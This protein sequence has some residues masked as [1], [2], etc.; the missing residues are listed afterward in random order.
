MGQVEIAILLER[1]YPEYLSAKDIVS[2]LKMS[3]KSVLSCLRSLKKREEVEYK[4]S[5]GKLLKAGWV[6][7]YRIKPSEEN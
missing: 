1:K 3:I 2:E 6:T 7:V 5:T 4:I